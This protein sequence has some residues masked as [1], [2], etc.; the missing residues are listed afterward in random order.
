MRR[1]VLFAALAGTLGLVIFDFIRDERATSTATRR[2]PDMRSADIK[3]QGPSLSGAGT[4]S[5]LSA[6]PERSP[7]GESRTGLFSSHSWQPPALKSAAVIAAAPDAPSAPAMPYRF[8]GTLVQDG[9]LQVLLAKGDA[10]IPV[11][12]GETIDGGYRVESIGEDQITLIYLPLG[13]K[14]VIPFFSLLWPA[15]AV[16]QARTVPAQVAPQMNPAV[17]TSGPAGGATPGALAQSPPVVTADP[18]RENKPAQLLWY[19]PNEVKLGT[20]FSVALRVTSSQPVRA[21]P[22]QI[23]V[24]P[25]LLETVAVKPG[26]FFSEGDRN[27]SYR[28]NPDGSIFVGATS[29][30]PVPATD[31]EFVVLTFKPLKTAPTAELSIASLN[32]QGPAGRV[33]AFDPLVGFK[34]A[35]SP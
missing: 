33:I 34:T 19:G 21:S 16:A 22:M 35:I 25:A 18:G 23:R 14:E 27:F 26:R 15:G 12:Q 5:D 24:N 32:L 2:A 4:D 10:V 30:N 1:L 7:L 9:K 31:A 11:Q 6:L 28:V 13:K 8:A 3:R 20:Q 17:A 29:Q